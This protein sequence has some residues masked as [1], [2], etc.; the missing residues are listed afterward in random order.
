MS[1][2]D[3]VIISL[4]KHQANLS[5]ALR[6]AQ[7]HKKRIF[8]C[9][10]DK[11]PLVKN[12]FK[13]A[14]LDPN[15]IRQWWSQWPDAL[16]GMPTGAINGLTVLDV[17]VDPDKALDGNDE[18]HQLEHANAKL[19]DTVECLT[20]RGGRH[21]Y[22][23]YVPGVRN[24]A[25]KLAPGLDIRGEGGYVILPPSGANGRRYEW[26]ASS[27][28][29][30]AVMPRWLVVKLKD[31]P[32]TSSQP[33]D[34][35]VPE[36][37]RNAHLAS[38]A[39]SMRRP[40]MSIEAITAALKAENA[41]R[42]DPPL[43]DAEVEKIAKSVGRYAPEPAPD[44]TPVLDAEDDLALRF[45]KDRP[46]LRYVA[47]WGKW[48]RWD[49]CVWREDSTL[50]IFSQVREALR[51]AAKT[52]LEKRRRALLAG[53]T[54]A[55]I[56]RLAR[57]DR[58]AAATIEQWDRH[59]LVL[60][61]PAGMVD[62]KT[63]EIDSHDPT[64][65]I[66]KITAV[67]PAQGCPRW[68]KFLSEVTADNAELVAFLQRVAGYCST[69]LTREH[70]FFF[71]YGTGANGKG[72]FLNTLQHVLNDYADVSS[73]EVFTETHAERHPTE[74]AKLREMRLVVAQETE[75]GK[76]WAENRIKALTGGDPISAR[77]MRQDFFTFFPKFKLLIA[78]N[79]KPKLKNIDEA[80]RRRLHF[81]PFVV[82]IP[83]ARRELDLAESLKRE[84]PGILQ[85]VIDGAIEYHKKGLAPP[86][87]VADATNEYFSAEDSFAQWL[88]DCTEFGANYTSTNT[89]LFA[90]WKNYAE[91]ANTKVG[92]RRTFNERMQALGFESG[93]SRA[94]GG[95]FWSGLQLLPTADTQ[96][97]HWQK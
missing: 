45:I 40:G 84:W 60:N 6:Y 61:T 88:E 30:P 59:D 39:G 63:G 51:S 66:T 81:I 42:C 47:A 69:G 85:W 32:K 54:V 75:E 15:T 71:L 64:A 2:D 68:Q 83:T 65:H 31:S 67:S 62:L 74:L 38:L 22:F 91:H 70:A 20:P 56:E 4:D 78:G 12:G 10:R 29:N 21:I 17:D 82:T 80:M 97:E 28:K 89:G 18:L 52:A 34:N 95:R 46:S 41:R 1:N 55:A 86:K 19:P 24:S 43:T 5:W 94:R 27:T 23:E 72:T 58:R 7:N 48:L 35:P 57:S 96:D 77:F 79:H 16:I 37:G 25:S 50:D 9:G 14:T 76:A 73:M 26:E 44:N 90:S 87:V 11:R 13:E 36:G 3:N 49:G 93:N 92:D 33:S 53:R 8:P